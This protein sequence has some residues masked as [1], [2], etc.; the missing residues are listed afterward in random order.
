MSY[1]P[2]LTRPTQRLAAVQNLGGQAAA[3]AQPP[4]AVGRVYLGGV[5]VLV[6]G[7]LRRVVVVGPGD[8]LRH[9]QLGGHAAQLCDQIGGAH[10]VGGPTGGADP[11]P[12]VSAVVCGRRRRSGGGGQGTASD[13]ADEQHVSYGVRVDYMEIE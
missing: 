13:A 11:L 9:R 4:N 3:G 2:P 12:E 10:G 5:H 8:L 1:H 7:R 6:G